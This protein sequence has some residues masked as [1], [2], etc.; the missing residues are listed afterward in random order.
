MTSSEWIQLGSLILAV[1]TLVYL[2]KYAGYTKV[3]AEATSK[4]AVIATRTGVITNPPRL[5][6]IGSGPALDVEWSLSGTKKA[7]KISFLEPSA[8]HLLDVNLHALE[9]GAVISGTN[10]VTITC[11]YTS[12]SG[13]KTRSESAYDFTT[14]EFFGTTFT[15]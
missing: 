6:N 12:I 2:I 5:R 9:H 11:S 1:I 14:G 7:G 3:I 8:E 4:P 15:E 13:R 10:K